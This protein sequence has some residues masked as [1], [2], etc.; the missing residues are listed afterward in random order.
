MFGSLQFIFF[1]I[2]FL[3]WSSHIGTLNWN[4]FVSIFQYLFPLAYW[5][6]YKMNRNISFPIANFT[7]P[8]GIQY[9]LA[10]L[11]FDSTVPNDDVWYSII[12]LMSFPLYFGSSN[13]KR[14]SKRIFFSLIPSM[15][16][17]SRF[18]TNQ[19]RYFSNKQ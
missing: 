13:W 5:T 3:D 16:F 10:Y 14:N 6:Q 8:T 4:W 2:G 1:F 7:C 11:L 9:Y 19:I 15:S 17:F 18:E 12:Y